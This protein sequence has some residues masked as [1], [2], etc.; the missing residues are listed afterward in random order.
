MKNKI[1]KSVIAG[2]LA[3][4]MCMPCFSQTIVKANDLEANSILITDNFQ[5]IKD[6]RVILYN[7]LNDITAYYYEG[8]ENGY[9]IIGVDGTV[10][11]YSLGYKLDIY[12]NSRGRKCYYGGPQNYYI[13]HL[14]NSMLVSYRTKEIISKSD[15]NKITIKYDQI[16]VDYLEGEI[17]SRVPIISSNER[18]DT[19]NI[20]KGISLYSQ[21]EAYLPNDT[22]YFS[23]NNNDNCGSTAAAIMMFYYYDYYDSGY[24]TNAYY[25]NEFNLVNHFRNIMDDN[26]KGTNYQQLRNGINTYLSEVNKSQS[27]SYTKIGLVFKKPDTIIQTY[28]NKGE[29]C[30]IGLSNEPTYGNHWV[31]CIGYQVYT[32]GN[33]Y[34]VNNGWGN[35][36]ASSIVYINGTYID[37]VVYI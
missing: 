10:I 19:Q 14:D 4:C 23:Y 15:I 22:R 26:G 25:R 33:Y 5:V 27:C 34:K 29:P 36:E 1:F 12:G 16:K 37:G 20:S 7:Y 31:V 11:E 8:K 2:I 35:T 13:E 3:L 28:I 9:A 18:V 30:I 17:S 6:K 32:S 24:I 21:T